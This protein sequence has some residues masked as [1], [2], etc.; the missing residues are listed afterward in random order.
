VIS[1]ELGLR[2]ASPPFWRVCELSGARILG[3]QNRSFVLRL[4][5]GVRRRPLARVLLLADSVW[6]GTVAQASLLEQRHDL[7]RS[8]MALAAAPVGRGCNGSVLS[9]CMH[10]PLDTSVRWHRDIVRRR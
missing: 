9:T 3:M 1:I 2:R 8:L 10:F 4:W 6:I 7:V 5:S